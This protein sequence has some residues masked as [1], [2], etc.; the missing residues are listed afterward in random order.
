MLTTTIAQLTKF[1]TPCRLN[2][3]EQ[4]N[5]ENSPQQIQLCTCLLSILMNL[6]ITH[7]YSKVIWLRYSLRHFDLIK[8][9]TQASIF[10]LR[11][12]L[13]HIHYT[14][15]HTSNGFF[16]LIEALLHINLCL[17]HNIKMR[18]YRY[19]ESLSRCFSVTFQGY[20]KWTFE[21]LLPCYAIKMYNRTNC[22]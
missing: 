8:I 4:I 10:W 18:G 19:Q 22:S 6:H 20:L 9:F 15:S 1:G 14:Q 2:K 7:F 12:S 5:S 16:K 21:N 13:R 11:Y 3:N 17:L